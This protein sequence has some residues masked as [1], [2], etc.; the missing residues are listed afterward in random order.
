M[1]LRSMESHGTTLWPCSLLQWSFWLSKLYG[2]TPLRIHLFPT[3]SWALLLR[4]CRPLRVSFS[5]DPALW[6]RLWVRLCRKGIYPG[7]WSQTAELS[8]LAFF[9]QFGGYWEVGFSSPLP[10][11][12]FR[13]KELG[14][15]FILR[16]RLFLCPGPP[17]ENFVAGSPVLVLS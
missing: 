8:S 12:A 3:G 4:N 13:M 15:A 11:Q 17:V 14:I 7:T 16:I 10:P 6:L 9:R 1:C 5:W 2:I